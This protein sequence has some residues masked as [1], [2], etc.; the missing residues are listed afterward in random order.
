MEKKPKCK[1][2]NKNDKVVMVHYNLGYAKK[3]YYYECERCNCVVK[4]ISKFRLDY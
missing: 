2:C 1:E 3:D 4:R